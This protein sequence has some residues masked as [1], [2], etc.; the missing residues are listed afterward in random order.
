MAL[1]ALLIDPQRVWQ[2]VWRWFDESMLDC[3][4]PLETTKLKGMTLS[5]LACL[6]RCNSAAVTVKYGN[7]VSLEEFRA[8]VESITSVPTTSPYRVLIAS[9]NRRTLAQSGSGHFSPIG[10]Y[11][12][13]SDSVLI[14]DVA[15]FKYPPHWVPLSQLYA[16]FQ[17]VDPETGKPRGY[18]L[19]EAT[20]RMYERCEC[21]ESP[22]A[23][24]NSVE[25]SRSTATASETISTSST[26]TDATTK[27]D[28]EVDK[29]L[30]EKSLVEVIGGQT[31]D[32]NHVCEDCCR[33]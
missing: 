27:S 6:A 4:Q 8:D 10:G 29:M 12:R 20:D 25:T 30:G 1:N 21:V 13:E 22:C 18:L 3:C 33:H 14:L 31:R 28:A 2:G 11:E 19:L 5:K 24:K 16:A 26:D 9:Y 17:D 7:E 32:T 15:R 23:V